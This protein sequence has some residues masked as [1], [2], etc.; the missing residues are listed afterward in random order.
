MELKEILTVTG[1]PGL[2]KLVAQGK[3]RII[4]ESLNDGKRL[5]IMN[6]QSVSSL[7]D[8]A[9]FTYN[10]EV[11]L[12]DVFKTIYTDTE[13][14]ACLS[15]KS[16]EAEIRAYFG[17]ILPEYDVDRVYLSDM[18]KVFQ[19]FNTLLAQGLISNEE[20]AEQEAASEVEKEDNQE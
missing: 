2:F 12:G 3:N 6:T 7:A 15:H 19:W 17:K 9:I 10:E 20:K 1:K 5:P 14:K 8:I 13:G 18:K 11:P 16:S 4:V